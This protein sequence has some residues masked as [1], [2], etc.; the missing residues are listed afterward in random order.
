MSGWYIK[1]DGDWDE[2]KWVPLFERMDEVLTT[3]WEELENN[4]SAVDFVDRM[5]IFENPM[6]SRWTYLLVT[7]DSMFTGWQRTIDR[8]G[9]TLKRRQVVWWEPPP[10]ED[11]YAG[12]PPLPGRWKLFRPAPEHL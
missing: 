10:W 11:W 6:G 4:G 9:K 12:A 1:S 5:F 7:F 3:T 2:D 8:T